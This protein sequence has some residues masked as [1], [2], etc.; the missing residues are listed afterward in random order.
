[1]LVA[2]T[3]RWVANS[4]EP[5]GGASE[6]AEY[7]RAAMVNTASTIASGHSRATLRPYSDICVTASVPQRNRY[8]S[9]CDEA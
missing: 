8:A 3:G 4:V 2:P 7:A 5:P 9:D 1:M 6:A